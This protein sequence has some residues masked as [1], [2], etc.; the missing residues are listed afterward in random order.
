MGNVLNIMAPL[1][2]WSE[3]VKKF[4]SYRKAQDKCGLRLDIR[5]HSR[6]LRWERWFSGNAIVGV[7]VTDT[8]WGGYKGREEN[9]E[10]GWRGP[11]D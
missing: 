6:D 11:E 1:I 7:V 8:G 4:N 5:K 10:R 9:M 3:F 2:L